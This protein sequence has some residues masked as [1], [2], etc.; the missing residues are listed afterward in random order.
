MVKRSGPLVETARVPRISKREA[1][2]IQ[3]MAKFMAK[4][5]EECPKRR[6]VLPDRGPHPHANRHRIRMIIA[7]QLGRGT[8]AHPQRSRRKHAHPAPR[9]AIKVPGALHEF[10]ARPPHI[11]RHPVAD[12]DLDGSRD[13]RQSLV[14]RQRQRLHPVAFKEWP[15]FLSRRRVRQHRRLFCTNAKSFASEAHRG[16][17]RKFRYRTILLFAGYACESS[18]LLGCHGAIGAWARVER[19][20]CQHV[21]R[22]AVQTNLREAAACFRSN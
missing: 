14:R 8:L 7:K 12:R 20:G 2:K 11:A 10:L 1:M 19:K 17:C 21:A 16:H 18:R 6:N 4:R 22:W 3:V 15:V 9:H 13:A 5:A